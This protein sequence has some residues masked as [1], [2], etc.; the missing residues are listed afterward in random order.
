MFN[1]NIRQFYQLEQSMRD[2]D[3]VNMEGL[4]IIA[5]QA[6]LLEH[7]Y[8][9]YANTWSESPSPMISCIILPDI[10]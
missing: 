1:V 8:V 9:P 3:S 2:C 10:F 5:Q 4:S 6:Q 7:P